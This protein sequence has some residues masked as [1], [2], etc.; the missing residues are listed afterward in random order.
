MIL[1]YLTFAS[2]IFIIDFILYIEI[3]FRNYGMNI[4]FCQTGTIFLISGTET[5][6][7]YCIIV[8]QTIKSSPRP[9][10]C[11]HHRKRRSGQ[12]RPQLLA[13][14]FQPAFLRLQDL[15]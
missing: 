6:Y 12:E 2:L 9:I 8:S 10:V 15:L 7:L 11:L 4:K 14:G 3:H 5:P 1:L 13:L